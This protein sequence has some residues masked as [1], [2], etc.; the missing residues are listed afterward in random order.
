MRP[1]TLYIDT[2]LKN[3]W[4]GLEEVQYTGIAGAVRSKTLQCLI[5]TLP[6]KE[7]PE[8][9]QRVLSSL[10]ELTRYFDDICLPIEAQLEE[11]KTFR[12]WLESYS[13][14]TEQLQLNYFKEM[15]SDSSPLNLS[16]V[17]GEMLF[18]VA[19]EDD[20]GLITLHII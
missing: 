8:F 3:L 7:P 5:Q 13:L 10:D 6:Q 1:L 20:G 17:Y 14:T 4:D 9:Y 19:Y 12:T 18:K 11:V 2:I 15:T 16:L